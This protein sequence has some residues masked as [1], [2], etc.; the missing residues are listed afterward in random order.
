MKFKFHEY[1]VNYLTKDDILYKI[2]KYGK[3][4]LTENDKLFMKDEEMISPLDEI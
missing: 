2:L 4:S 1:R 3:E